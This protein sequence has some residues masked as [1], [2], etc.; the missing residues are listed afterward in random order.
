MG[1]GCPRHHTSD[2]GDASRTVEGQ[3]LHDTAGIDLEL[4]LEVVAVLP[5]AHLT[6]MG[7]RGQV[8]EPPS[9]GKVLAGLRRE[10]G[11]LGS[12]V[13]L[14]GDCRELCGWIFP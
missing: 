9:H 2:G 12:T 14:S 6:L 7:G 3:V 10:H 5:T 11:G 8:A 4:E 1:P 13:K